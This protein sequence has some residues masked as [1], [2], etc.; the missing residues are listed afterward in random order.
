[1]R[2]VCQ[3]IHIRNLV[4]NLKVVSYVHR[5]TAFTNSDNFHP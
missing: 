3:R 2:N 5:F 4:S 1:M